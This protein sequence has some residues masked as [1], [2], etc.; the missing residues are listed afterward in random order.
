MKARILAGLA[1]VIIT[2]G[3]AHSI[4][5]GMQSPVAVA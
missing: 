1:A 3:I 2:F 4:T 5:V